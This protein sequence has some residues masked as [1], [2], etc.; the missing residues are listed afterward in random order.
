MEQNGIYQQ[1]LGNMITKG[2]RTPKDIENGETG[3]ITEETE[4]KPGIKEQQ[5]KGA[6]NG[7]KI[8]EWGKNPSWKRKMIKKGKGGRKNT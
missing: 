5:Q 2:T 1:K 8:K 3:K 4:S 7:K 6:R